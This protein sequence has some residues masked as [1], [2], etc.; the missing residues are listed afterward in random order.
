MD[1]KFSISISSPPD[2]EKI[3]AMLDYENEQWAELN[4]E[5]ENFTLEIYPRKNGQPWEFN[6]EEA[7]K[8][9]ADAKKKLQEA[10]SGKSKFR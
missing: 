8:I 5:S 10:S 2:R 9:L 3:V 6:Y 4:Q 1:T 7:L